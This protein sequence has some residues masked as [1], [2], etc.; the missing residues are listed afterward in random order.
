MPSVLHED[1][2]F[3]LDT[4]LVSATVESAASNE[5]LLPSTRCGFP[6]AGDSI[7]VFEH[8]GPIDALLQSV[9]WQHQLQPLRASAESVDPVYL[10]FI[11]QLCDEQL[12]T[13][14]HPVGPS[15][16]RAPKLQ[17]LLRLDPQLETTHGF[18]LMLFYVRPT[19]FHATPRLR[20]CIH[21]TP[22]IL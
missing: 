15:P 22:A 2:R 12:V 9:S 13:M 6:F 7:S 17:Q 3:C 21:P 4:K 14:Q 20:W 18:E 16:E 19:S 8:Q 5:G 1:G 10:T 11:A